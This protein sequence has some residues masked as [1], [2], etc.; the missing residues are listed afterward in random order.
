MLST[1]FTLLAACAL[2]AALTPIEGVSAA[3]IGFQGIIFAFICVAVPIS[4]FANDEALPTRVIALSSSIVLACC[5]WTLA[6][7]HDQLDEGHHVAIASLAGMGEV[8]VAQSNLFST[9]AWAMVPLCFVLGAV[10]L[11]VCRAERRRRGE[12][13]DDG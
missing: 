9:I 4:A 10:N 2:A 13:E 7:P 12:D 6:F 8:T 3:S 11:F 1:G 5:V